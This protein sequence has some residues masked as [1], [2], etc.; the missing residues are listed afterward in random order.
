MF[1]FLYLDFF[2]FTAVSTVSNIGTSVDKPSL[3]CDR[4]KALKRCTSTYTVVFEKALEVGFKF[5]GEKA[6]FQCET[7]YSG[8]IWRTVHAIR[9]LEMQPYWGENN[10]L[11]G[12]VMNSWR[13]GH[14]SIHGNQKCF[15]TIRCRRK[16][17]KNCDDSKKT[18]QDIR[19]LRRA[20]ASLSKT[21]L[22][23]GGRAPWSPKSLQAFLCQRCQVESKAGEQSESSGE[24]WVDASRMQ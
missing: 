22:Q 2:F 23:G 21:I 19:S 24:K 7:E 18:L 15:K 11:S 17:L 13:K 20:V 3:G 14:E 6:P 8:Q 9:K 10:S 16:N 12:N 5:R 1:L 4:A